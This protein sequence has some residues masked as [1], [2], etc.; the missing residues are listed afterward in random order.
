MANIA[1]IRLPGFWIQNSVVDP[2]EFEALD[3]VRPWLANFTTGSSHTPSGFVTVGGSGFQLIGTG[4]E[5]AASG[6]VTV[7]S[8]GAIYVADGGQIKLNGTG[9]AD[10]DLKVT[11]GVALIDAET[12]SAIR[13]K[14]GA[15][16]DVF[17]ALAGKSTGAATWESGASFTFSSG[18]TL[19]IASGTTATLGALLTVNGQIAV[20][21]TGSITAA[22]GA[23]I[24]GVSG[25]TLTW[26]GT[27]N[28]SALTLVGAS[29]WPTM[30]T[31]RTAIRK[32]TSVIPLTFN[33]GASTVGPDDP[34][35]WRCKSAAS[36]APAF[37]TRAAT[38]SGKSSILNVPN[39]PI[40]SVLVSAAVTAEGTDS[41]LISTTLPIYQIVSWA[42][43]EGGL[44]GHSSATTDAGNSATFGA[45]S[46]ETT[47]AATGTTLQ[48]TVDAEREYGILVTHPY[49]NTGG[50]QGAWIYTAEIVVEVSSLQV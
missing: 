7:Q 1:R 6:R 9:A 5:V 4:H 30:S 19:N 32:A 2:D 21:G 14:A 26:Q 33:N 42:S 23:T 39:L 17:G 49:E 3:E 28:L 25:A 22:S 8:T 18:S 20:S 34:D 12:G 13:V 48:K 16:L 10:I 50:G 15:S 40:G 38:A 37:R 24:L 45:T 35:A 27:T 36:A 43:G 29:T 41:G 31:A 11:S 47:I 44:V 46:T